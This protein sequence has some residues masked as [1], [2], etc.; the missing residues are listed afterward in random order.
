MKRVIALLICLMLTLGTLAGCV[1]VPQNG[2]DPDKHVHTYETDWSSDANDHWYKPT[3]D[4]EDAPIVKAKHTDVNNDGKCDICQYVSCEHTYAEEWTADC[5]NHWHAADCGHIVAGA[6]PAAHTD[7]NADGKCDV[8]NYIIKDIHK[9]L[10]ATEWTTDGQ[11]HWYAP[12]CEHADAEVTKEAHEINAA[13]YC[14]ICALKINEIDKT[15]IAAVLAAAVAQNH[16]VTGGNVLYHNVIDMGWSTVEANNDVYYTIGN[17]HTYINYITISEYEYTSNQQWYTLL[18]E[19]VVDAEGNITTPAEIFGVTTY[20]G[21][22]TLNP[23]EGTPELLNGYTYNPS[24]I[25]AAYDDTSTLASTLAALYDEY[26]SEGACNVIIEPASNY[27]AETGVYSFSFTY[28]TVQEEDHNEYDADGNIINENTEYRTALYTA[29]VSFT[30]DENL[31]I[32]YAEFTVASYT[33]MDGDYTYDPETGAVTLNDYAAADTYSYVVSQSSG[34]RSYTTA[35]PK[36]TLVPEKFDFFCYG[37]AI[38]ETLELEQSVYTEISIDNLYPLTSKLDFINSLDISATLTNT[39]N[40][41]D[42]RELFYSNGV[43]GLFCTEIGSYSLTISYQGNTVLNTTVVVAPAVPADIIIYEFVEESNW[44]ETWMDAGYNTILPDTIYLLPGEELIFTAQ[45]SPEAAN[46]AYT[47]TNSELLTDKVLDAAMVNGV[48]YNVAD[49]NA[50]TAK[51]FVTDVEGTYTFTFTSAEVESVSKTLTV[52]VTTEDQG[53]DTPSGEILVLDNIDNYQ[54]EYLTTLELTNPGSFNYTSDMGMDPYTFVADTTATY[55]FE[56]Y[57]GVGFWSLN[58]YNAGM[59]YEVNLFAD[60]P[61]MKF[62]VV[63]LNAGDEFSFHYGSQTGDTIYMGVMTVAGGDIGGGDVPTGDIIVSETL[64][65]NYQYVTS[66]QATVGENELWSFSN[67]YATPVALSF[68]ANEAGMYAVC[69]PAQFGFWSKDSADNGGLAELGINA[70]APMYV[71]ITLEAGETFEF[72]YGAGEVNTYFLDVY[73]LPEGNGTDDSGDGGDDESILDGSEIYVDTL[74]LN[75]LD[76]YFWSDL[77][78]ILY[79]FTAE[80]GGMYVVLIPENCGIWLE[81]TYSDPEG[82]ADV[83]F[84]ENATGTEFLLFLEA[85][86]SI[87]F[88]LGAMDAGEYEFDIF[89]M[90]E[91]SG[92]NGEYITTIYLTPDAAGTWST[93]TFTPEVTVAGDYVLYVPAGCAISTAGIGFDLGYYD[94]DAAENTEGYEFRYYL[95]PAA[96]TSFHYY[97]TS[98]E[99]I[100]IE[101]YFPG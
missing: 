68:T 55:I 84:N 20:D 12:I 90:P 70:V 24:T 5:T 57:E 61:S 45:I 78:D 79:T 72:Y 43:F 77:E 3:C 53:G 29:E 8:C 13:G 89:Y 65:N 71:L 63:S 9:H 36:D 58:A 35:Y 42:T 46:Q 44:G 19:A 30:V 10:Y 92:N 100:A 101:L 50:Y 17:G 39:E 16:M 99:E 62:V 34:V 66:L 11:Y 60:P 51:C 69:V 73:Y 41:E 49:D 56:I 80:E 97:S 59:D 94:M 95:D 21:G 14:N 2:D 6:E 93:Q 22:L 31:V 67:Y 18:S 32:D 88:Y 1:N 33:E 37:D 98:G 7:T 86:E 81:E 74:T 75:A 64:T 87:S 47:I 52:I 26:L 23:V 96:P 38:G 4:C 82:L 83:D 40:P 85:G 48:S 91:E 15:D 27:D 76:S 54:Y 25:L 28:L